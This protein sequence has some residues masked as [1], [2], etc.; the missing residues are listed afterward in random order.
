MTEFP[1]VIIIEKGTKVSDGAGGYK[2]DW[3]VFKSINAHVQPISGK[4]FFHAQQI[5]SEINYKVFTE[6]DKEITSSMRVMHQNKPLIIDTIIDQGGMNEVMVL[7]C[8]GD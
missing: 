7:M 4:T 6:F 3:T 2:E 8:V 1:H 5:E